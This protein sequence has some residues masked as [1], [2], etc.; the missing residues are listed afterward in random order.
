MEVLFQL[1]SC[2]GGDG[3]VDRDDRHPVGGGRGRVV[4]DGGEECSNQDGRDEGEDRD[5]P[6]RRRGGGF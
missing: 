6:R 3:P 5:G 1:V 2:V 4:D